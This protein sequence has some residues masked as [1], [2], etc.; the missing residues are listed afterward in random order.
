[1]LIQ[2]VKERMQAVQIERENQFASALGF[3]EDQILSYRQAFETADPRGAGFVNLE[4]LRKVLSVLGGSDCH[5][6]NT[7]Y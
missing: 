4:Q 3:S 1:M 6:V 7:A 5:E 2:K